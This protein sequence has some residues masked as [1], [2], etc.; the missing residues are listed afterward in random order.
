MTAAL[1]K[2]IFGTLFFSIFAAVTGVG[3]VVPLLPVY[4]R[5]LGASGIYIGFIFASFSLSRTLLLPYFG[6]LSDKKGR[7]KLIISGLLA[8]ALVSAAFVFSSSV[9]SLVAIR[10]VQGIA[11]AMM[12][13][14]IQAY[15]GDITP[16]GKEGMT[17]GIFNMSVFCGLSIGPI[18]G[19]GIKDAIGLDA[20][21]ICMGLLSLSGFLLSLFCLPAARDEKIVR[22]D[23]PPLPWKLLLKDRDVVGL[24]FFRV[25][26]TACIGIIWGFLPVLADMEFSLSS[27]NI[28]ILVMLGVFISGV[29]HMPMGYV[30][31]RISREAMI[32]TGGILV[33]SSMVFF[34]LAHSVMS[35]VLA[36][37][38]FGLGGGISMPAHMAISVFKGNRAEAMGS[39]M[40]LMTMAHSFGMLFGSMLAGLMMDVFELRGA[41]SLG[42]AIC[43]LG[44][45]L[46]LVLV[47]SA[48]SQRKRKVML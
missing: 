8:Y 21:F 41:F 39:L 45:L 7:K 42:A 32:I 30:A 2:K 46:Y 14:V 12:M 20:S 23:R 17:M 28:G 10:F 38:L 24:F 44:T 34:S 43:I 3:I 13:P 11:S 16:S 33:S 35:L 18:I 1:D 37:I 4:A 48:F 5:E 22:Q 19:G 31:D 26:Y 40:G 27:A 29:I 6:R 9:A 36:S 25:A 15:V 47:Y